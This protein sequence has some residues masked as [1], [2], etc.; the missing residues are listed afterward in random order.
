M[1]IGISQLKSAVKYARSTGYLT[2]DLR[3]PDFFSI[4]QNESIKVLDKAFMDSANALHMPFET[5]AGYGESQEAMA[6]SDTLADQLIDDADDEVKFRAVD[7]YGVAL[8]YFKMS[9]EKWL[10]SM[11]ANKLEK[12]KEYWTRHAY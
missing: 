1:T 4:D 2:H 9:M 5:F 12:N 8:P 7:I 6:A 3:N 10:K 11:D